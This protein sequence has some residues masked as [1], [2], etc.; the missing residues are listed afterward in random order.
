MYA[1]EE[2]ENMS[3]LESRGSCP[4]LKWRHSGPWANFEE[5]ANGV[6]GPRKKNYTPVCEFDWFEINGA[7]LACE[8]PEMVKGPTSFVGKLPRVG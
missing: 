4:R 7:N 6:C 2:E 3:E 8:D 5:D 1:I